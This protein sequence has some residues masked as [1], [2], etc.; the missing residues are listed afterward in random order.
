MFDAAGAS[1]SD[2]YTVAE[3]RVE[4]RRVPASGS[5]GDG[6]AMARVWRISRLSLFGT[7]AKCQYR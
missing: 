6:F 3:V 2:E 4:L 1:A 7:V 5:A